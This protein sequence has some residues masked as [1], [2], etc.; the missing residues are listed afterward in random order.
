[1]DELV[2]EYETMLKIFEKYNNGKSELKLADPEILE[3]LEDIYQYLS[4]LEKNLRELL[5]RLLEIKHGS[6][7]SV[8]KFE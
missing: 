3:N 8:Y 7:L 6:D 5:C 2:Q 1:V 4:E